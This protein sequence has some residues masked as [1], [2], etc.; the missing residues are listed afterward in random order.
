M[1][2]L[3]FGAQGFS[4]SLYTNPIPVELSRLKSGG[5]PLGPRAASSFGPD[6]IWQI[7][8]GRGPLRADFGL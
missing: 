6:P 5:L 4:Q 7:G 2:P 3:Y 8:G 1:V